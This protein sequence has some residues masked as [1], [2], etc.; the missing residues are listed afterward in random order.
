M[1]GLGVGQILQHAPGSPVERYGKAREFVTQQAETRG[2]DP[3]VL[4]RLLDARELKAI[5]TLLATAGGDAAPAAGSSAIIGSGT[6]SSTPPAWVAASTESA[7]RLAEVLNRYTPEVRKRFE[8]FRSLLRLSEPELEK[9]LT[10]PAL[11]PNHRGEPLISTRY[12]FQALASLGGRQIK[13]RKA[14]PVDSQ[15]ILAMRAWL[16]YEHGRPGPVMS[17]FALDAG[18]RDSPT[19]LQQSIER[20]ALEDRRWMVNQIRSV[21]V[22]SIEIS[23]DV[24]LLAG[25]LL[26]VAQRAAKLDECLAEADALAADGK[27]GAAYNA[28]AWVREAGEAYSGPNANAYN[29]LHALQTG[30]RADAARQLRLERKPGLDELAVAIEGPEPVV[31]TK[32]LLRTLDENPGT[33]VHARGLRALGQSTSAGVTLHFDIPSTSPAEAVRAGLEHIPKE[34]IDSAR[35][36]MALNAKLDAKARASAPAPPPS[37]LESTLAEAR[38]ALE[39]HCADFLKGLGF[40]LSRDSRRAFDGLALDNNVIRQGHEA[41]VASALQQLHG[42]SGGRGWS[43]LGT[44]RT[45]QRNASFIPGSLQIGQAHRMNYDG[46]R[47]ATFHEYGHALMSEDP[48]AAATCLEWVLQRSEGERDITTLVNDLDARSYRGNFPYPYMGR[49][50][51]PRPGEK[52]TPN[53]PVPTEVVSVALEHFRSPRALAA[54]L[55]RDLECSEEPEATAL[56]VWTLKKKTLFA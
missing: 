9:A 5:D 33:Q 21:A 24:G 46:V 30:R 53:G 40:V 12:L 26:A 39:T 36:F 14:F 50:Y 45:Q 17:Q 7:Q 19:K 34:L 43:S 18:H 10:H 37:G 28:L 4:V 22:R 11:R 3:A 2:L 32:E 47:R 16:D 49:F 15:S 41:N 55:V 6:F 44:I 42:A 56:T 54:L 52:A 51:P 31:V 20:L 27:F 1:S 23:P 38:R 25:S 13:L 29:A 8:E 35:E 48:E